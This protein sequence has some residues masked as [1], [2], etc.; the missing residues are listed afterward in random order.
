[1]NAEGILISVQPDGT[2]GGNN[3]RMCEVTVFVQD[4]NL[5]C[6]GCAVEDNTT[7]NG[8][9]NTLNGAPREGVTVTA[10]GGAAATVTDGFGDYQIGGV[11][12]GTYVLEAF[13]DIDPRAGVSTFDVLTLRYHL[14]GITTITDPYVL[15]AAG[16][17]RDGVLDNFDVI[18][19]Q[20]L[21]LAREYFYP[22]G[23]LW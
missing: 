21:V 22:E 19:L 16:V 9:V 23:S 13:K 8:Q 20:A 17:N 15:L 3:W 4:P 11:M 2:V 7:I 18:Q 6:N 12:G 5:V 14:L 1:M 10:G